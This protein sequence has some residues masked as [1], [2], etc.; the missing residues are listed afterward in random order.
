[1]SAIYGYHMDNVNDRSE[2]RDKTT[3]YL[4]AADHRRLKTLAVREGRPTA[5]LIR[6]AVADYVRRRT[7]PT[8]PLSIGA[9]RSGRLD[10]S[11]RAEELLEGF[12]EDS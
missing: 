4:D 7:P 11:E 9:A 3:I 2:E 10:L 8:R 12:G 1:M 6:E 5:E